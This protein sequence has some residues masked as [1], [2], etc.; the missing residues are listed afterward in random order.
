[1]CVTNSCSGLDPN[2]RRVR[3]ASERRVILPAEKH[4]EK[5]AQLHG[6][7][8]TPEQQAAAAK[9]LFETDK[10]V[11]VV[12]A[13]LRVLELRKHPELRHILL[14]RY[15]YYDAHGVRR[16]PGAVLRK[17]ILDALRAVLAFDD[18]ALLERAATTY[19]FLFGEAAG[20]LRASALLALNDLDPIVAG[21]HCVRLLTDQYTSIMSGEPATTAARVL[22]A[23]QQHLPLYAYA[24]REEQGVADVVAECLRHL[25]GLPASLLPAVVDKFRVSDNEII[26]LGLFDLLLA[27]AAG[28]DYLGILFEFLRRTT[29]YNLYR[30]LVFELVAR[31]EQLEELR[32]LVE[33]EEDYAKVDILREALALL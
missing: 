19:E 11:D 30:Y 20:D 5:I 12:L 4:L 29:L 28:V 6:Q 32:T 15:A 10:N 24:M 18:R 14:R 13:A 7:A 17:A 9:R 8:D 3:E 27:H 22:A 2:L 33:S 23:A 1:M 16:D 25:D 21:Y 31:R 26:L